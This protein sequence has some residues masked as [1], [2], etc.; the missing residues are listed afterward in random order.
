M[1]SSAI[2]SRQ[3]GSSSLIHLTEVSDDPRSKWE[4]NRRRRHDQVP[5]SIDSILAGV[6]SNPKPSDQPPSPV[7]SPF[8][9]QPSSDSVSPISAWVPITE[10]ER[11]HYLGNKTA[12][13]DTLRSASSLSAGINQCYRDYREEQRKKGIASQ[14]SRADL[15]T[16]VPNPDS[17]HDTRPYKGIDQF[18]WKS[19]TLGTSSTP[20]PQHIIGYGPPE[21][22]VAPPS[23]LL[24]E[25]LS[26]GPARSSNAPGWT[27]KSIDEAWSAFLPHSRRLVNSSGTMMES[28]DMVEESGSESGSGS[29]GQSMRTIRRV[30]NRSGDDLEEESG[31]GGSSSSTGTV[32]FAGQRAE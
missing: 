11:D 2:S 7:D 13:W 29:D 3:F 10:A 5:Y 22:T 30:D 4:R 12:C 18:H 31:S 23:M 26:N 17:G 14:E 32:I 19:N 6:S 24:G 27:E 15:K 1:G 21:G 16:A 8:P 20:M 9:N 28:Y 25:E